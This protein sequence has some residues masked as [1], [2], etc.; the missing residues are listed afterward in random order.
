METRIGCLLIHGFGGKP[1]DVEPLAEYLRD[2]GITA[3]CPT[4]K[5]HTGEKI[6]LKGVSYSQWIESAQIEMKKLCNQCKS[7]VVLGFSMGGLIAVSLPYSVQVKGIVLLNTP[8]YP[9]NIKQ[10]GMNL[11]KDLRRQSYDHFKLYASCISKIPFSA[12]LEFLK[13]LHI[14]KPLFKEVKLPLFI[15]QS[16]MDDIVQPRSADYIYQN[17]PLADKSLFYY[18]SSDHLI[19]HSK[20]ARGLFK[21]ILLFVEKCCED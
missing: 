21:D 5:G 13:F 8:I 6:D 9:W 16:L 18:G 4:L 1:G 20:G 7:I 15:V 3:V 14:A 12:V 10:I 19:C 2:K 11:L 17:T